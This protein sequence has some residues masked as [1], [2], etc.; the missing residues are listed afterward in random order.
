VVEVEVMAVEVEVAVVKVAVVVASVVVV[1]VGCHLCSEKVQTA[2][3]GDGRKTGPNHQAVTMAEVSNVRR[4]LSGMKQL[5]FVL[6]VLVLV[7]ATAAL[8][9]RRRIAIL[10]LACCVH[11]S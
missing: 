1:E 7:Q 3:K 4:F 8:C 9:L 5:L 2:Y 6:I 11:A 10:L